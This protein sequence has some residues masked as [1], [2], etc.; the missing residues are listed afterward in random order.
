MKRKDTTG[1]EQ[2]KMQQLQE[3][4]LGKE[5]AKLDRLETIVE[6]KEDLSERVSP[7]IEEHLEQLRQQFPEHY[8]RVVD[9][10]ME[11]K[12]KSSSEDILNTIYPVLGKMIKKY[13]A[14]QFQL[15]REAIDQQIRRTIQRLNFWQR[16]KVM[17]WG[18]GDTDLLLVESKAPQIL[19]V[20]VIQRDSGLLLGN[21]SAQKT[22]DSDVVAGMLTAIKAFVEDAF[23]DGS[24]DLGMIEYD[25]HKI[26]LQNFPAFFI[27]IALSGVISELEKGRLNDHLLDFAEQEITNK[28][29]IPSEAGF[30]HI[31]Q[32]LENRF[33]GQE[34]QLLH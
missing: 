11:E 25:H 27:A 34:S 31:S 20:F 7:I 23:M 15:L 5:R 17:V 2:E 16:F 26:Y 32:Q 19:E 30:T 9:R 4:L 6:T 10:M 33:I 8:R 22:V 18:I 13:I 14:H 3:I 28:L 29:V 1:S 12:I 21:A 24:Q